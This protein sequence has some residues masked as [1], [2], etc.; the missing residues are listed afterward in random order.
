MNADKQDLNYPTP[1]KII[2]KQRHKGHKVPPHPTF[3]N[4]VFKK[5]SRRTNPIIVFFLFVERDSS[6][7]EIACLSV[8]TSISWGKHKHSKGE[9]FAMT[10][11]IGREFR[12]I[13]C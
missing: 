5:T 1:P 11:L 8:C 7:H 13:S 4:C 12:N 9:K 10:I 3:F 2:I 6:P